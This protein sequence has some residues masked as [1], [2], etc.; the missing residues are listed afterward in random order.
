VSFLYLSGPNASNQREQHSAT[1]INP[2]PVRVQQNLH[3][4]NFFGLL[5]AIGMGPGE[6]LTI[7]ISNL[8]DPRYCPIP[9]CVP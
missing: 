9:I 5:Q 7:P 4:M 6:D 3:Q 2:M 8:G 1:T